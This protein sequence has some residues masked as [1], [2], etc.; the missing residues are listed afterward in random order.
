[1]NKLILHVLLQVYNLCLLVKVREL[2]G[3]CVLNE[4]LD[5]FH[6]REDTLIGGGMLSLH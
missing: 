6:L 4:L 2:G 1:M 5:T 3:I